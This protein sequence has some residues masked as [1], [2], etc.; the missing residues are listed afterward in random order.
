MLV[1]FAMN[2]ISTRQML[3]SENIIVSSL[4]IIITLNTL[5]FSFL[6]TFYIWY[7][8]SHTESLTKCKRTQMYITP[9]HTGEYETALNQSKRRILIRNGQNENKI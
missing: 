5:S 7:R 9:L 8:T 4:Q 3:S 6:Y 2:I 1:C